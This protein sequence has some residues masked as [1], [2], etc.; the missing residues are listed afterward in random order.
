[1]LEFVDIPPHNPA[2]IHRIHFI[3]KNMTLNATQ[4]T[5]MMLLRKKSQTGYDISK[6]LNMSSQVV[7]RMLS[8]LRELKILG[9]RPTP[10]Q[11][12]P[13][14]I[15]HHHLLSDTEQKEI[16]ERALQE[17]K[18]NTNHGVGELTAT[19]L[20]IG[21]VRFEVISDWAKAFMCFQRSL[22]ME[23]DEQTLTIPNMLKY[24]IRYRHH[25]ISEAKKL[26]KAQ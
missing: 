7:Y 1:M 3:T 19:F 22:L 18:F 13:A 11:G 10:V 15:Y 8:T 25:L 9:T 26:R 23:L 21:F 6:Q 20:C 17:M 24:E 4:L 14:R 16:I 12:K 2:F 5:I